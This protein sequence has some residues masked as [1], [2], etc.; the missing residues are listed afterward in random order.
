MFKIFIL[1]LITIAFGAEIPKHD[2]EDMKTMFHNQKYEEVAKAHLQNDN[3]FKAAVKYLQSKEFDEILM[4]V[5]NRSEWKLIQ[6]LL[7]P[8]KINITAGFTCFTNNIK[9]LKVEGEIPAGTKKNLSKYLVD[10][11]WDNLSFALLKNLNIY[12]NIAEFQ[13]V[14]NNFATQE[15]FIMINNFKNLPEM[16]KLLAV[17][18]ELGIET[19]KLFT[20]LYIFLGWDKMTSTTTV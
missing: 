19:E 16:K 8:F 5:V 13:T 1:A 11:G 15:N 7:D 6:K 9:K 4:P 20:S 12:S 14:Y 3:E 18:K 10:I 17:L 2:L